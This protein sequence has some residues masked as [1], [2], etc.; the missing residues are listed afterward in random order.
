[1]AARPHRPL[2]SLS[3]EEQFYLVIPSVVRSFGIAGLRNVALLS[4]ALA[5]TTLAWL[6]H[7]PVSPLDLPWINSFV[8]F[9]FFAAGTLT[10]IMLHK[11]TW[12]PS[13]TTRASLL[14]GGFVLFYLVDLTFHPSTLGTSG[15][16]LCA[17]YLGLLAGTLAIFFAFLRAPVRPPHALVYL[18]RISFGLYVFHYFTINFAVLGYKRLQRAG[19]HFPFVLLEPL[20]LLATIGVAAL[21][22]HLFERPILRLK[23]KFAYIKTTPAA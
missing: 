21:S 7:Q 2:W 14:L 9:Q 1:M 8:Q 12:S 10:A 3:I 11:R 17:G 19:V 13:W 15:P 4:I 23:E 22:Y 6:G 16:Q 5:Y 18:G 20:V